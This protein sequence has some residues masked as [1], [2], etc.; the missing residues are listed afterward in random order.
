MDKCRYEISTNPEESPSV[1]L[2]WP[3]TS[4]R[5][6]GRNR[7]IEREVSDEAIRHYLDGI[8]T[9]NLLTAEE[10]VRARQ[11]HRKRDQS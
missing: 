6:M 4:I 1:F 3:D 9:Y 10:E 11:S 7:A 8:G 2:R 5:N